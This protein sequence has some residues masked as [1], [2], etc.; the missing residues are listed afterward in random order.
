MKAFSKDA[1]DFRKARI[2]HGNK[3]AGVGV[4]GGLE[5]LTA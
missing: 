2:V 4:I 3:G 5:D 1:F